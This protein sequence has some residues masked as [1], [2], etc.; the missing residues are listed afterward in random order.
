MPWNNQAVSLMILTEEDGGFSGLF[1]YSPA[2]GPGNLIS[3]D[4]AVAGLDPY[5]NAY[6][7]GK[8]SYGQVGNLWY[9]SVIA[10]GVVSIYTAATYAGPWSVAASI[11]YKQTVPGGMSLVSGANIS[12]EPGAGVYQLGAAGGTVEPLAAWEPGSGSATAEAWHDISADVAAGWTVSTARYQ[13]LTTGRVVCEIVDLV[14]PATKPTD[15]TLI[16]PAA[17]IPAGWA[18][19]GYPP[20]TAAYHAGSAGSETPALQA[21]P[22]GGIAVFGVGSTSV[23]RMDV[24]LEWSLD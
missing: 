17:T 13:I 19:A 2:E 20:I 5:G 12:L 23:S 10:D 9:A 6:L 7:A 16:W 3:S 21:R 8:A 1:G 22:D 18:P 24:M 14:P 4:A 11:S 15:G